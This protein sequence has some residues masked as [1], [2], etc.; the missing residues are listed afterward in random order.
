MSHAP[1]NLSP[2]L[3]RLRADGYFRQI[4]GALLVMRES[5]TSPPR[6]AVRRGT[7]ISSLNM[8]GDVTQRPDSHQVLTAARSWA[9]GLR[10]VRGG[11]IV[12]RTTV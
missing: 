4:R 3:K 8:A 5:P 7:L 9:G 6:G 1:F 10:A 11:G 2:D 12:R